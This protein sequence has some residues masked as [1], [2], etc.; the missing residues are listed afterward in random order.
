MLAAKGSNIPMEPN[1]KLRQEEKGKDVNEEK[2]RRLVGKLLN[3]TLTRP[4]FSFHVNQ[5]SQFL[6]KPQRQH[7]EVAI[8]VLSYLKNTPGMGFF[9]SVE[10]GLQ[11]K[12]SR[13]RST[14]KS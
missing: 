10:S 14:I 12:A 11:L 6:N 2:Y 8:K 9:Y 4:D 5:L 7:Y 13:I 3:L 1:L